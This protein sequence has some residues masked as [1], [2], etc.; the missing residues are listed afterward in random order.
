MINGTLEQTGDTIQLPAAPDIQ[1]LSFRHFRGESDFPKM[2]EVSTGSKLADGIEEV[3][4]L[5]NL[6][7]V[8]SK[9]KNSDP[10]KDMVM[11]EVGGKL[12]GY[13]RALWW[14]ELDGTRIYGFV[15]FLLPE[16]R[17]KGI[18]RVT[19]RWSEARLYEYAEGH[20]KEARKLLDTGA[21]DSQK[22]WLAAL[23]SEGYEPVRYFYDMV[24]PDLE[25]VPDAQLPEGVE[26]RPVDKA[27]R[28]QLHQIWAAEVEAFK[29]HWGEAEADES[30][31]GRWDTWGNFQPELWQVAWEGDE[32]VGM[33]RNYINHELNARQGIKRGYTEDISVRRPWRKRGV[34]RALIARS[35]RMLRDMGMT[36]AALG[37]DAT[38]PNGAYQLYA[39]MGFQVVKQE[40]A[41]RKPLEPLAQQT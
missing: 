7:L 27:N 28:E 41:Y 38:N 20:P 23:K 15:S 9:L 30:D 21:N 19:L 25:N 18:E 2:I 39:S 4:T 22:E 33:V 17:G 26:V 14:E 31:F 10:Y 16:W 12:V 1:G 5:E 34:A 36:Q 11:T 8:Y 13:N 35:F 24:R 29:D 37:V 32:V 40:A 6:K 3:D